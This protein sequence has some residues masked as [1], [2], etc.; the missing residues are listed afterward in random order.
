MEQ[1]LLDYLKEMNEQEEELMKHEKPALS[2]FIKDRK[3]RIVESQAMMKPRTAIDILKHPRFVEFGEHTHDFLEVIYMCSGSLELVINKTEVALETDELLFIK[4]G[5][6][7]AS[8]PAGFHDIAV[9]FLVLPEFLN[10]PLTMLTEDTILRRFIDR[11]A[12]ND[13][14]KK[15]F[16]HFHLQDMKEA[17]NLLENMV[18][19]ILNR[20]RNSRRILQATMGVLLLELSSRTYKITVGAPSSYDQQIVLEALGYIETNYKT[21]S[22]T[23]FCEKYNLPDYYISRLMKQYSP[24]T[25]TKYLQRRRMLQAAHFLTET[26]D[27]V[28]QI[29][30]E[31]GYENSSHFHKLFKEEFGMTPKEYRKKFSSLKNEVHML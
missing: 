7:H 10:Y 18:C 30:L 24:Y 21:A 27:S 13:T 3:S 1:Q 9:H 15:E 4:Q 29:V 5:T 25:F 19:S 31:V 16:L 17:R 28:E 11:A 26:A 20:Q 2:Y 23:K 6:P 22:L 8:K 14:E 12:K